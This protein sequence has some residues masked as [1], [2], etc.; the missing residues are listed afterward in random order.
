MSSSLVRTLDPN[1]VREAN[2][3]REERKKVLWGMLRDGSA[4]VKELRELSRL[5]GRRI[6]Y[7]DRPSQ[8]LNTNEGEG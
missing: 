8:E 2:K 1:A 7:E 5:E 3:W 6:T 4:W